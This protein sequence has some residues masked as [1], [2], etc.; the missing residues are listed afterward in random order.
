MRGLAFRGVSTGVHYPWPIHR[1]P[2]YAELGC[3]E[4]SLPVTERAALE[5]FSLPMFPSLTN[6][7]Q[8]RVCDAVRDV[9]SG[10]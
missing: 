2:A 9:V 10:V 4:G 6:E 5:I 7:Q 1:M 3:R 8:D